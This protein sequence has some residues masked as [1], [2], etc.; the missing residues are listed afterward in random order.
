MAFTLFQESMPMSIIVNPAEQRAIDEKFWKLD[1]L[2]NRGVVSPMIR[3]SFM[4]KEQRRM[5]FETLKGER[6]KTSKYERVA[7]RK[8]LEELSLSAE[9]E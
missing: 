7:R 1:I 5:R 6:P 8:R 3:D 2:I 4:K 9:L